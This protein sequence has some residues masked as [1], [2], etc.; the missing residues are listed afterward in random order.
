MPRFTL[1]KNKS[2][3]TKA[4]IPYLIDVQ[5]NLLGDLETRVVIPVCSSGALKGKVLITLTPT[6]EL[7]GGTYVMLTPQLAG[8]SKKELGQEVASLSAYRATIIAALD[9]LITGI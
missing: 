5:S 8:I 7:E 3:D 2:P 9:F 4:R 1:Y 6:F